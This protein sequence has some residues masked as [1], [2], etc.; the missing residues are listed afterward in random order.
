MPTVITAFFNAVWSQLHYRMLLLT[1]L[2]FALSVVIWGAI[3][4][5]VLNPLI[6]WVQTNFLSID[7]FRIVGGVLGWLGLGAIKAIIVPLIAMWVL[8]PLMILTALVF[9]GTLAMPAIARHVGSRNYPTLQRRGGGSII[10]SLWIGLSSFFIFIVLWLVTL[11]LSAIPMLGFLIQPLLWGWLT[12]RVL[13]YDALASYADSTELRAIL[14]THRWSLLTIGA[15]TGTMGAAP[16]LMWLGGAL[17]VVLAPA[18][19][20]LSIWLYVLVFIFTGLWFQHYC[21][22][23]LERYRAALPGESAPL[24]NATQWSRP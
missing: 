1:L 6:D 17:S 4:W 20:A 16:T 3:L 24:S 19:A 9:I 2:P 5:L 12:Y 11:P 14:R 15:A 8:L 13:A 10:G 18:L 7:G 22:G 23:A 21:L